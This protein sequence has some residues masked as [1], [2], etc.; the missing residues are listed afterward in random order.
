M[1]DTKIN[2]LYY[3]DFA[4]AAESTLKKA[5]LLFDELHVMDRPS[6]SFTKNRSGFRVHGGLIGAPSPFRDFEALFKDEGVPIYVHTAPGGPVAE[7]HTAPG[8]PA[9]EE[10]YEQ[11]TADVNDLEFL[12]RF[13]SG[14]KAS[15]AFRSLQIPRGDYGAADD[16]HSVAQ[17]L[18]ALDLVTGL[19]THESP[20]ALFEDSGVKNFD[21]SNPLGCAKN[22]IFNAVK[23]SAQ[24]NFALSMGTREG[25]FP[26][27][28]AKP[29]G[30][31]LGAKYARA[32]KKLEPATN[33]IQVA[34]LGF[35]IFDE[36]ISEERL[37]KLTVEDAF[38]YRKASEKAREEFLEHLAVLQAKQT[39]IGPDGNYAGVIDKLV[40]TEIL[41]AARSFRNKL[42]TIGDN[43][44][45][46]LATGVVTALGTAA[47]VE[48]F[49]NLSW[50]KLLILAGPAGAYVIKAAIEHFFAER[51][52][53]RECSISYILALDE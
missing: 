9:A 52:A 23:C 16:Q 24:L 17:K 21:Y 2:V 3:P 45:G 36:L 49:M 46:K 18:I 47:N 20:I 35:A 14:L 31:L 12:K 42:H 43:L 25:F 15:P 28:D 34:D 33:K 30:D 41:P 39:S 48:V 19:K 5:I 22:L 37:E 53:K 26:L 29:Y 11:I 44:F 10:L 27:A 38:R 1:R 32:I 8:G 40:T 51:A 7:M 4:P 13:Q 50:D 6:I